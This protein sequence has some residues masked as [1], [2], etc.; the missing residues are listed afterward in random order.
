[1]ATQ[2][3]AEIGQDIFVTGEKKATHRIDI[4][5]EN[6]GQVNYGHK[7]LADTQRKGIRTGVWDLPLLAELAAVSTFF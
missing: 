7:F 4:L 2:Y 1:M 3:Q 5:M 6:M